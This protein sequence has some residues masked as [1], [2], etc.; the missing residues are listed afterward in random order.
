[1][2]GPI[3]SYWGVVDGT[4]VNIP[5]KQGYTQLNQLKSEEQKKTH[6]Y[7]DWNQRLQSMI[8]GFSEGLDE[9][10]NAFS[11]SKAHK[12]YLRGR[13]ESKLRFAFK[14]DPAHYGNYNAYHFFLTEPQMGT[15]PALNP[16]AAKL[17]YE[18]INYCMNRRVDPREALTA[19]AAAGNILELMLNDRL[20]QENG[21]SR[22]SSDQM[23]DVLRVMDDAISLYLHLSE[24]WLEKG[25]WLNLSDHRISEANDRFRFIQRIRD[26]H[27]T[28]IQ[29]I[30][31][32][33]HSNDKD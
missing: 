23:R 31:K 2:Q 3:D 8:E 33:S 21:I 22:Y 19:A 17:A 27:E 20:I 28:S 26:S 10:T 14:L 4:K 1:M 6:H 9:R 13:I 24:E 29:V 7:R 15:H 25:L 12:F 5:Q 32:P 11:A 30:E 16:Q 18:T